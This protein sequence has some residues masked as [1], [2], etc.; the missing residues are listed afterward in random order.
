MKKSVLLLM[1]SIISVFLL[2]S[3]SK[4]VKVKGKFSWEPEK[5]KPGDEITIIY[6]P[7]ST[8]LK[9]APS[10][11]LMVYPY[12][13]GI[14]ETKQ[15]RMEKSGDGWKGK[16]TT[17]DSSKGIL[18]K[19]KNDEDIDNNNKLGYLIK[20]YDT[21]GNIL[22]GCY[23]GYAAAIYTW[24]SYYLDMDRDFD[25][26]SYYFKKDFDK[27][28][29]IKYDYM[30]QYLGAETV[31]NKDNATSI[32]IRELSGFQ[33]QAK[34]EKDYALLADWYEKGGLDNRADVYKKILE[35][36][37]PNGEFVQRER[38]KAF[39]N[40]P[41]IRK[42]LDLLKNFE[43]QYPKSSYMP[44]FYDVIAVKY[45]QD[46]Q[47]KKLQDFMI[48]NP[49]KPTTYR[50]YSVATKM[51]DNDKNPLTALA[52]AKIGVDRARKDVTNPVDKK[53]DYQSEQEW[54]ED[55]ESLLGMNLY[56]YAEALYKLGKPVD[57]EA[58][59]KEAK[60]LTQGK[61]EDINQL[62]ARVLIANGKNDIAMRE[63]E[64]YIKQG[65]ASPEMK[66]MLKDLYTK[67]HGSADGFDSYMAQFESVAK[68]ILVAKLE[69]EMFKRTAPDFTL[70]DLE[71]QRVS[72]KSLR[73][74]SVVMDF[75]A[76]WCGPCKASFPA[77]AKALELYK[78]NDKVRF[79][80]IN[81]W[82][83]VEDKKENAKE[84]LNE[85]NYSFHVLLDDNNK[86]IEDYKVSGIP[87]KFVIDKD[88]NI[89]FMSVGFSGNTDELV[90]EVTTMISMLD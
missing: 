45:L 25:S 90:D 88:G 78:N 50:F 15:I 24:G 10:V 8:G 39:Y 83:N 59:L 46:N 79:L 2:Y 22:P 76:T 64:N 7:D 65:K 30:D 49:A 35:D 62:Y 56:A 66:S 57:A 63:I 73:G 87:T 42:K 38:Y 53:P 37:Y 71:G 43:N 23:A 12:S 75:W 81:S 60:E 21:Q 77:M 3:C 82:E 80:F 67:N 18:I 26:S 27:N 68:Q 54:K 48:T 20:L 1:L 29:S 70:T 17:P 47:F 72:L 4:E 28:P 11:D 34:N 84:F 41:D 61:E 32:I 6:V 14:D 9:N 86:V 74:K 16:F 33:S 36:K 55:R 69:K 31:V 19:F 5:P 89:R 52:I 58:P 44:D 85:N 51:L 40:E 13:T